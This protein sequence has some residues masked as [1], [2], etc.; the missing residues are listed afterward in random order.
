MPTWNEVNLEIERTENES[1]CDFVRQK[2]L[3]KLQDRVQ[4]TVIAYYSGWLQKKSPDGRPHPEAAITDLDMNGFMAVVHNVDRNRGLDLMLHTPGGGTEA[5]RALVEYIYKMF[6]HDIRV[7]VPHMAMSA[8][9]M[10]ACAAKKNC[11]RK[12]LILRANRP[13][14]KGSSRN[15]CFG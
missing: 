13:A 9:T 7:I 4:R 15:G 14:S 12:T 6:G 10:I 1:P 8:G 5:T 3:R 2:Y 11:S